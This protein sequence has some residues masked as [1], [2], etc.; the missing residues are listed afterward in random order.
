MTWC[1]CAL[2]TKDNPDGQ[3][4]P[5]TQE[6][7]HALRYSAARKQQKLRKTAESRGRSSRTKGGRSTS[8]AATGAAAAE[9][10]AAS[11]LAA[12]AAAPAAA[13]YGEELSSGC[14]AV[15]LFTGEYQINS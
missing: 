2:C 7:S 6:R 5:A 15:P 12:V 8:S 9:A 11:E 1:K 14:A 3:Y 4:I 10:S 13:D